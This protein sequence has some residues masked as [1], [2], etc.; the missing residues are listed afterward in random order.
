MEAKIM[1]IIKKTIPIV[2]GN[3]GFFVKSIYKERQ[4]HMEPHIFL[5]L[6]DVFR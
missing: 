3:E 6:L 2:R 5:L 1:H 4:I